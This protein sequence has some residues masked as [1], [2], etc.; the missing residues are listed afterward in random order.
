MLTRHAIHDKVTEVVFADY[1]GERAFEH[2]LD[3]LIRKLSAINAFQL[4]PSS[5]ADYVGSSA[6]RTLAI[7]SP[8]NLNTLK[9]SGGRYS[10]ASLQDLFTC[11]AAGLHNL[12]LLHISISKSGL[13]RHDGFTP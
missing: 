5:G 11:C 7:A 2:R 8:K 12:H 13:R 6:L 10:T 4:K 9:L 1:M 3:A